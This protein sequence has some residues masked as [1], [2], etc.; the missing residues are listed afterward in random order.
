MIRIKHTDMSLQET[1]ARIRGG[2]KVIVADEG[3]DWSRTTGQRG[4]WQGLEVR[5]R[6][7]VMVKGN[8]KAKHYH[9]IP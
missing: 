4:T 7:G 2:R 6:V 8:F 3:L 5:I 1:D 9:P